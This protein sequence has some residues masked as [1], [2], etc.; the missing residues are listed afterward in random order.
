[1][2]KFSAI[3][4]NL[5]DESIR[6]M[7]FFD[8]S[9]FKEPSKS[10]PTPA[11]VRA[12]S[13]D[14][15]AN[16]QPQ[17]IIFEEHKIFVKFGPYVTIAE[18]Q[19]L[20][21][22]KRAF[23]DE[24]PVPEIFGWRV[25]EEDYVFLYMELIQG[26]T[27]QDGWNGLNSQDKSS[28]CDELCQIVNRLRRLEQD[29]TDQFIGSISHQQLLDYV[30]QSCPKPGPFL[31]IKDFN[32]WFSYLPQLWLPPSK[33]YNDPYRQFLPDGGVIKFT[34]GDL[35]RGNIII[36][37]SKPARILAIVDWEQAGWYPDYWEYCKALYTCWY[38]DEW[39][40]D[41]VDNFLS[42]RVREFEVFAEYTMAM[43]SV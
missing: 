31:T 29:P 41:W 26:Q 36:S 39:R 30:F 19:C 4:D 13:K 6:E 3:A 15:H 33:K 12:L 34:H 10:L 23:G 16:P 18:A 2:S 28:L 17:P 21:M 9:F 8:S 24:I 5:P 14:I 42:P 7:N 25:D 20:W 35:H 27:L 43:G 38:E 1:M 11:Q 40:R 22:I 37:S 32:D